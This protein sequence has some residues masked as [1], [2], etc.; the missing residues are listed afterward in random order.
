MFDLCRAVAHFDV[1]K[2]MGATTVAELR[3][4]NKH[5]V[6]IPFPFATANHQEFNARALEQEG[7]A[8][9]I[10]EKDLTPRLLAGTVA[11]AFK[12]IGRKEQACN[13]PPVFPQELLAAEVIKFIL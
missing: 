1:R 10:L 12:N 8:E 7:I 13:V 3:I 5:A 4:L 9:V 11:G 2:S 6:L